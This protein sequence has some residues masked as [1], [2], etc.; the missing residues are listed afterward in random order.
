VRYPKI[1]SCVESNANPRLCQPICDTVPQRLQI[2]FRWIRKNCENWLLASSCP[3]VRPHGK[4]RLSLD[5]FSWNLIIEY[6]SKRTVEA[7]EASLNFD[8]RNG[9]FTRRPIQIFIISR[10][11]LLRIRN[12][13][14][15][16]GKIKTRFVFSNFF[17]PR[18]SCRLWENVEK[19][20][21]GTGHRWQYG[22]C[23]LHAGY[24]RLHT[25]THNM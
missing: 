11:F 1:F 15:V 10:S 16:V 3:S 2:I 20:L 6:F 9:Y 14:N 5:G 17:P 22:A 13:S 4:T 8:K 25:H 21:S 12:I 18:K 19:Y 23:A 7:I 24:L